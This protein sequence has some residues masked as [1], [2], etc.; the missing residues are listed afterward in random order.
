MGSPPGRPYSQPQPPGSQPYSDA[1]RCRNLASATA[2][3]SI[4]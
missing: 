3:R 4:S 1:T 2:T